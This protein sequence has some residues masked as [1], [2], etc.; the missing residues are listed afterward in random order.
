MCVWLASILLVRVCSH[1]PVTCEPAFTSNTC[2]EDRKD[3][4]GG[5]LHAIELE[6]TS[7]INCVY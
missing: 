3:V 1:A 7:G 2:D 6:L 4:T 5:P